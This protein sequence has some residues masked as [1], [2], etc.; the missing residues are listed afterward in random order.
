MDLYE[1]VVQ[2]FDEYMGAES[3]WYARHATLT[4]AEP[5]H[6]LL[7]HRVRPARVAAHLCRRPGRPL[8]R[9]PQG[10]QRPGHAARGRRASSTPR[11]TSR[12]A[13]PRTAGRRPT[14][15]ACPSRTCRSIPVV[16]GQ[17]EPLT[18]TVDLPGRDVTPA[19]GGSRSAGSRSSCWTATSKTTSLPIASSPPRLYTSDLELRIS[20]EILLGIGGVR[21]LRALG[22]NPAVWHMNEGHS[23]FLAL[24]R[25]A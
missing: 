23:A 11:A 24:E 12:S 5:A 14:T 18:V 4:T 19:C 20:Q 3:T 9:S 2:A 17:G 21:A 10:G 7:L 13:S 1:R 22:Y 6:R 15:P 8:R 16:D 25:R